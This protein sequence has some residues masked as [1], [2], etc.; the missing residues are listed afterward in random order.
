MAPTMKKA[1]E[2]VGSY[3]ELVQKMSKL[4]FEK[5]CDYLAFINIMA[6]WLKQGNHNRIK[7]ALQYCVNKRYE[8]YTQLYRLCPINEPGFLRECLQYFS[9]EQIKLFENVRNI[10]YLEYLIRDFKSDLDSQP[11]FLERIL[12]TLATCENIPGIEL[13]AKSFETGINLSRVINNTLEFI[14]PARFN[15]NVMALLISLESKYGKID[16]TQG[17]ELVCLT[18]KLSN[19][20][21]TQF[22]TDRFGLVDNRI[23][24]D[25][26]IAS[27]RWR[28]NMLKFLARLQPVTKNCFNFNELTRLTIRSPD[29][30]NLM[31]EILKFL[32]NTFVMDQDDCAAF[33][34]VFKRLIPAPEYN[35]IITMVINDLIN[36]YGI[37]EALECFKY[38]SEIILRLIKLDDAKVLDFSS[39]EFNQEHARDSMPEITRLVCH[40]YGKILDL[41]G[42]MNL[43]DR[44]YRNEH[45]QALTLYQGA[46]IGYLTEM[47]P[48]FIGYS[49][50]VPK[51]QV[52]Y[53]HSILPSKY[54]IVSKS[55]AAINRVYPP[56]TEYY[57][58]LS[59]VFRVSNWKK[60]WVIHIKN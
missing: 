35:G 48:E 47:H 25:S 3:P 34:K 50:D 41:K 52:E 20:D 7:W 15:P 59:D 6:D 9:M 2:K 60:M 17:D 44:R 40:K 1:I 39:F 33:A 14:L 27:K 58:L 57:E 43:F 23:L 31:P 45:L 12:E 38:S 24:Y 28:F 10:A 56:K 51:H 4:S 53:L 11:K 22:L 32:Y 26:W 18:V 36:K 16:K 21:A 19:I 8:A 5:R 54:D 29:V 42:I 55:L 37:R 30:S 13:F 49:Q 46:N